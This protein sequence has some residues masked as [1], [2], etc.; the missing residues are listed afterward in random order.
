MS[1][2]IYNICCVGC[3]GTGTYFIKELVRFMSGYINSRCKICLSIVDGDLVEEKNLERQCFIEEDIGKHKA[4]VMSSVAKATFGLQHI[5]AFPFFIDTLSQLESVYNDMHK[6]HGEHY[7]YNTHIIDILIGAVDNHR[8]RQVMEKYFSNQR[9]LIYYDA[10]N[11]YSN[12]EV[13]FGC[14]LKGSILGQSRAFYFPEVLKSREKR[15]SEKSCGAVN[16]SNPQHMLTNMMAANLLLGKLLPMLSGEAVVFGVAFFDVF[17]PFSKFY[18]YETKGGY[19]DVDREEKHP[20]K[21]KKK[22][23]NAG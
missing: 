21:G 3:G 23:K 5:Y 6:V 8:A 19:L 10:A 14:K 11:E 22:F 7:F 20:E 1:K 12:G 9:S 16:R 17:E 15:A 4:V 13:V 18:P 2:V